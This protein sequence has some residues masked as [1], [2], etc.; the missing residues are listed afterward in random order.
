MIMDKQ[1][2]IEERIEC[3]TTILEHTL[4]LNVASEIRANIVAA[5][6]VL[7]MAQDNLNM[8][9]REINNAKGL[10]HNG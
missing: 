4:S 2:T 9:M 7:N 10:K 8:N 3:V 5:L 1:W 6:F